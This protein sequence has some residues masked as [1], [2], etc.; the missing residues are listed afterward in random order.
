MQQAATVRRNDH[1][2]DDSRTGHRPDGRGESKR[3]RVRRVL[4][5][6]LE[7]AGMRKQRRMTAAAHDEFLV[8]LADRLAYLR[9]DQLRG[10]VPVL[11]RHAKG[12]DGNEWPDEVAIVKW[13]YGMEPPPFELNDY[14]VSVLRSR[15]GAVAKDNGYIVELLLAAQ[16]LGPPFSKLNTERL[17]REGQQAAQERE[18]LRRRMARGDEVPLERR[19][20]LNW[21]GAHEQ[22]ALAIMA[23]DGGEAG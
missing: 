4:I 10:L 3:D 16:R 11:T 21:Y 7:R 18:R 5:H 9:E 17:R 22:T 15:A 8:R 13:A 2:S 20:W 19:Q 12:K 14:V 1:D 23:G 6:P